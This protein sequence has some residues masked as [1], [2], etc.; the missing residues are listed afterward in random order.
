MARV[1]R[2]HVITRS[3]LEDAYAAAYGKSIEVDDL[4]SAR[5]EAMAAH[6]LAGRDAEVAA[7]EDEDLVAYSTPS[8]EEWESDER[9]ND[10]EAID[11]A[12]KEWVEWAYERQ[13]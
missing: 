10:R 5:F 7:I 12:L 8:K 13:Q 4:V 9:V 6:A 11:D 1:V 2:L 3:N